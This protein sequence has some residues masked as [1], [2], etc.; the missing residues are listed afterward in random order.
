MKKLVPTLF[1]SF[2]LVAC[3][4]H[5][6]V[7]DR[8]GSLSDL[9]PD[10]T[11]ALMHRTPDY[12]VVDPINS[13]EQ[14]I[15]ESALLKSLADKGLHRSSSEEADYLVQYTAYERDFY[16]VIFPDDFWTQ[17]YYVIQ[18]SS[19]TE[20][21]MNPKVGYLHVQI[22]DL[23]S[24]AVIW[25]GMAEKVTSASPTITD[26]RLRKGVDMLLAGGPAH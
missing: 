26:Q 7:R 1:V 15:I 21:R 19:M 23:P 4:S 17:E 22:V 25:E 6:G 16:H 18:T 2:F 11:F 10:S 24:G 12:R 14:Q 9:E 8:M 13:A 20:R 5:V 3:S